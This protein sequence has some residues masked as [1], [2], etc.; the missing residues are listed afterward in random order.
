MSRSENR[1]HAGIT[2]VGMAFPE[3]VLTNHDLE[4]MVETDDQ[5]IVERTGIKERRIAEPGTPASDLGVPAAQQ[6]LDMAGISAEEIDCLIVATVTPDMLFPT[7][8]CVLQEKIGAKN[9]W[10][11][12]LL[13]ACSG[14]LYAL[15]VADGLI[16]SGMHEKVLVVGAE[17][18]S[19]IIDWEDR[20]TCILFGDGAGATVV[21][22]LDEGRDGILEWEMGADGGGGKYLYMPAGGS[23]M[24]ASQ[25]TIDEKMH[26]V[27]QDGKNVFRFAVEGMARVSQSVLEKAGYAGTDVGNTTSATIPTALR[28]AHEEKTI[29]PDDLLLFATF[30]AG[31]TWGASLLRW[32]PGSDR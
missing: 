24:P 22:K 9:A 26:T 10:A 30:G 29:K 8:A 25:K 32:T 31:F 1:I 5:W 6:A 4:K 28:I 13:G 15:S 23:L 17:I 19:S 20:N 18:M 2:G 14:Y 3:K 12:D 27:V 11:F 16:R 21:Q 7:T